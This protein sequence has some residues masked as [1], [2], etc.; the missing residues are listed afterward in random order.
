AGFL[1]GLIFT[2]NIAWAQG[3]FVMTE[4][5]SLTFIL[6]STY[7]LVFSENRR[8][9]LIAGLLV[10]VSIGFKQY[11]LLMLPLLLYFMFREKE[12]R[13]VPELLAGML[14]P[15]IIMFGAIFV[16]YG[17]DAGMASLHRS[18]GVADTYLT[19]SDMGDVTSYR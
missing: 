6:L 3:Y 19:T 17:I 11:A 14:I 10:G 8:K 15:L 16:V 5:F 1:A 13:K 2:L 9:Y 7:L 12:L 18:F 4:P